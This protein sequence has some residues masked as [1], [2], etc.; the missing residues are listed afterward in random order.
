ML[1]TQSTINTAW[2]HST[3]SFLHL[4]I[5]YNL[6]GQTFGSVLRKF[7]KININNLPKRVRLVYEY[8]MQQ[9]SIIWP[10]RYSLPWLPCHVLIHYDLNRSILYLWH[11]TVYGIWRIFGGFTETFTWMF[12]LSCAFSVDGWKT[13]LTEMRIEVPHEFGCDS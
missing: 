4:F 11:L 6:H 5:A 3:Y 12:S 9:S 2:I 8:S 7:K 1:S 13:Q 10:L